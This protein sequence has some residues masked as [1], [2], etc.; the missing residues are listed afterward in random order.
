VFWD[1]GAAQVS[2]P[3]ESVSG[4]AYL[5][6]PL[7]DR[8]VVCLADGLGHGTAAREAA[9]VLL[10]FVSRHPQ[11][12][13]AELLEAAGAALRGTRGAAATLLNVE[14]ARVEAAGVGNVSVWARTRVPFQPL[15]APG[16]LGARHGRLRS[17]A[18]PLAPGDVFVLHTD[19]IVR[20]EPPPNTA[21]GLATAM[22][23]DIL[24]ASSRN[25]DD[26]TVVV[27][28]ILGGPA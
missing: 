6:L 3:G 11:L 5:I 22:A 19:G 2:A 17:Y 10:S 28:R 18:S 24:E 12:E 25:R 14:P 21:T 9:D 27:V 20:L 13:L 7:E 26:A 1:A 4:D 16:V 15:N 8:L 23:A